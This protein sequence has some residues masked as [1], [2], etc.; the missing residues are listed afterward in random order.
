MSTYHTLGWTK[1]F[2]ATRILLVCSRDVA[3]GQ[4]AEVRRF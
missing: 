1:L 4:R 3:T 2:R